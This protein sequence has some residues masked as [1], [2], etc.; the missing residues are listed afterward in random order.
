MTIYPSLKGKLIFISGGSSGIG[1][2]LARH[3]AA[4]GSTVAFCGT[5]PDGGAQLI[6]AI[7]AAGQPV[8]I[9]AAC[10]V[11]DVLA[12]QSLLALPFT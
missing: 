7:S 4:Q 2:D 3:F 8:P 6:D 5:R 10:D 12:Y 9:Y 1:A 11:R